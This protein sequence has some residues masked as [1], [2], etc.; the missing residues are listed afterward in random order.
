MHANYVQRLQFVF[1]KDGPTRY[2]GHL[3]L[4]RTLERSLKRARIPLAY[5]Q[6]YNARPRL[7]LAAA[8][9][10][11]FTSECEIADIWLL[12]PVNPPD[13]QSAMQAKMAPGI[14]I[15][16][17]AEVDLKAP[18]LQSRVIEASYLATI[19]DQVSIEDLD[20]RVNHLSLSTELFRE[21]RGKRYDLRPLILQLVSGINDQG[22]TTLKMRLMQQP[23]KT[24]RPD[25]V[26]GAMDL[27]PF[28]AHIH[29]TA[30]IMADAEISSK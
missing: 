13:A 29:R 10:L 18:A 15:Y 14:Q 3:D 20:H 17:I 24:G 8:L 6:G 7:Q 22:L 27:D 23:A 25:E 21:R 30:L 1:G 9:P 4:A 12:E 28:S 11:G 16:S 2:I 26:L 19:A 5:T